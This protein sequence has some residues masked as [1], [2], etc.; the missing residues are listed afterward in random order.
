[1]VG[2]DRAPGLLA[3]RVQG[4][5]CG[6]KKDLVLGLGQFVTSQL[7]PWKSRPVRQ[8]HQEV[9][10]VLC[11]ARYAHKGYLI[12]GQA[13]KAGQ[14]AFQF[15]AVQVGSMLEGQ[16]D[17]CLLPGERWRQ[18]GLQQGKKGILGPLLD[19][20]GDQ[21]PK[22]L[23]ALTIAYQIERERLCLGMR[24]ERIVSA[25]VERQRF[26]FVE[27]KTDFQELDPSSSL[28]WL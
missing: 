8:A 21:K 12:L 24:K 28:V 7:D 22:L 19:H 20:L 18:F 27:V 1:M 14:R 9:K 11:D 15:L 5:Q 6:D 13:K 26:E 10:N 25:Q 17:L 23:C 16:N 4:I 2:D 3:G